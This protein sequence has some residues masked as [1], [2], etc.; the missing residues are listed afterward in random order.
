MMTFAPGRGIGTVS[1]CLLACCGIAVSSQ[2]H[3]ERDHCH[4]ANFTIV[5]RVSVEFPVTTPGPPLNI[6]Q[7]AYCSL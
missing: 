4:L 6:C 3:R 5:L 2:L 7:A 1:P